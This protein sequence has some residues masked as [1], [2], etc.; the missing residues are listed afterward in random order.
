[1]EKCDFVQNVLIYYVIGEIDKI[2]LKYSINL[3][4]GNLSALV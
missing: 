3:G 2:I 4:V 1:M